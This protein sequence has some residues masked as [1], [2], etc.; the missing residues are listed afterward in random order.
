MLKAVFVRFLLLLA[1][2]YI[3]VMMII[4][5]FTALNRA[6]G[7]EN[8]KLSPRQQLLLKIP[9][10]YKKCGRG[11]TLEEPEK[12]FIVCWGVVRYSVF[13]PAELITIAP[14]GTDADDPIECI[15][16]EGTH[17]RKLYFIK[18]QDTE[19]SQEILRGTF[20]ENGSL[21][22]DQ[23]ID[24]LDKAEV[25]DIAKGATQSVQLILKSLNILTDENLGHFIQKNIFGNIP[26]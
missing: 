19:H 21:T 8:S 1:I 23:S 2:L 22:I 20:N 25:E 3:M 16:T 10:E 11:A 9:E 6:I 5:F 24:P 26:T 4:P 14:M 12:E 7:Q 18:N 15:V 17:L 13:G